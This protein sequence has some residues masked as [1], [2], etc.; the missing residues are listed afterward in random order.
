M[1][2]SKKNLDGRTARGQYI[3]YVKKLYPEKN[4]GE[5][6][7]IVSKCY[8][9]SKKSA[10]TECYDNICRKDKNCARHK[11]MKA[12][13]TKKEQKSLEFLPEDEEEEIY[14]EFDPV[15]EFDILLKKY[16]KGE[17]LSEH[18]KKI[19]EEYLNEQEEEEELLDPISEYLER[20]ENLSE[21]IYPI[22]E[23]INEHLEILLK[24]YAK[25]EKMS[26][27]EK[28]YV[29]D[30]LLSKYEEEEDI[31]LK[32]ENINEYLEKEFSTIH[33]KIIELENYKQKSGEKIEK[34]FIDLKNDYDSKIKKTR[35]LVDKNMIINDDRFNQLLNYIIELDILVS[36]LINK[37]EK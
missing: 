12:R 24:K 19:I 2:K 7:K 20:T 9:N 32:Q 6:Q 26:D 10:A 5:I 28:K 25:G 1:T 15:K 22:N 36:D 33:K 16:Y 18:D 27:L 11:K 14:G 4:I 34:M 8:D 21:Y 35:K 30:Y 37:N 23:Y 13:M 17:K 29:E 3:S 31:D